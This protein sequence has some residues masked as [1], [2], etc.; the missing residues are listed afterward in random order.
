M[1]GSALGTLTRL[2]LREGLLTCRQFGFNSDRSSRMAKQNEDGD[3]DET[4]GDADQHLEDESPHDPI[5]MPRRSMSRLSASLP[6]PGDDPP[7]PR[8]GRAAA[9]PASA[10]VAGD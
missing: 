9:S 7:H 5:L 6:R 10:A 2:G 1:A 8:S 3:D 4:D